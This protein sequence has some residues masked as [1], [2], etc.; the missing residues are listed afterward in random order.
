MRN[1]TNPV[2]WRRAGTGALAAAALL[3]GLAGTPAE[4]A[5][6][7]ML[8]GI[9]QY[10]KVQPLRGSVNDVKAMRDFLVGE[11]Q[12]APD[13][14]LSV[15]D[16]EATRENILASF[17]KWLVEGSQPGDELLFYYSGHGYQQSDEDGDES[18][19]L[20]ETLVAVDAYP[21]AGGVIH[22]MIS[23]DEIGALL[24][25]LGDREVT[26]VIDSCHSGT[27][28]RSLLGAPTSAED[29]STVKTLVSVGLPQ[30]LTRSIIGANQRE[31][32]LVE[33]TEKRVVWTA[34]SPVQKALVDVEGDEPGG[35][36]TRRFIEG[37][38]GAKADA[39]GN[40]KVSYAEL[41]DYV[42]RESE[43]YCERHPTVCG[44]G[45]TPQLEATKDLMVAAVDPALI[46]G[47]E[48]PP[49]PVP[50][51]QPE[52]APETASQSADPLA[53]TEM[54]VAAVAQMASETF[55][56]VDDFA[57]D[58]A[59]LPGSDLGIG[60][61]VQLQV[62]SERDGYLVLLDVNAAGELVQLF[63]NQYSDKAGKEN[64]VTAGQTLSV[65]DPYYGFELTVGGPAGAGRLLAVVSAEPI[66]VATLL[67]QNKDLAVV[68]R[69]E[70]Y[71]A[72]VSQKLRETYHDE[73][74]RNRRRQWSVGEL[75][76][77]IRE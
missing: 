6:R 41:L 63:P 32:S 76:Y 10:Q 48:I 29:L 61:T 33:T 55:A 35:V 60:D 74:G 58:V 52:A 50:A 22:N 75:S 23:D 38:R 40:G 62:T 8:V 20:D 37:M 77:T 21:D 3:A 57:V 9:D 24:D 43:T 70:D 7:A 36:F 27:V 26:V 31:K 65:P 45:L 51:P 42:Q 39:N 2:A 68:A 34:V 46:A 5:R 47:T 28:T 30:P 69:P 73:D 1:A 71:L 4:A 14:V 66:D 44:L 56:H 11:W 49:Q 67:A 18:D 59:M 13:A 53:P 15:T 25:E 17:R 19:N 64:R 16:G 12:F 54:E 72:E